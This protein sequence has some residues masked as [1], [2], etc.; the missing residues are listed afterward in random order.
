MILQNLKS[1]KRFVCVCCSVCPYRWGTLF[2]W[3]KMRRSQPTWCCYRQIV[4]MAPVTSLQLALMERPTLR[5]V[6]GSDKFGRLCE[7][8]CGVKTFYKLI[9]SLLFASP[10]LL[11]AIFLNCLSKDFHLY[12]AW[13]IQCMF[14]GLALASCS[15]S[16]ESSHK[17]TAYWEN[18]APLC[19]SGLKYVRLSRWGGYKNNSDS[20]SKIF[21]L[22]VEQ[23][24]MSS[25]LVII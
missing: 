25:R 4:Q 22:P 13:C 5:W 14:E 2:V 3:P 8:V 21:A 18:R 7:N 17:D 6:C 15:Y 11:V 19:W 12:Y 9:A 1:S 23:V 10:L 16:V 24:T 20:Y